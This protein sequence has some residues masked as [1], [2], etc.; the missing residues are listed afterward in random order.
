MEGEALKGEISEGGEESK[1][2]MW[3][4]VIQGREVECGASS[5]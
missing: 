3:G 5:K 1:G 4:R 2:R